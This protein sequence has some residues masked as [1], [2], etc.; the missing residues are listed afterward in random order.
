MRSKT[1]FISGLLIYCALSSVVKAAP[2]C[3]DTVGQIENAKLTD[4]ANQIFIELYAELG[5][6]TSFV[7]LPGKRLL[8]SFNKGKVKGEALRFPIIEQHYTRDFVRSQTPLI[9]STNAIWQHPKQTIAKVKP[10]G[11]VLGIVWQ[12]KH[13]EKVK[14]AEQEVI[15]FHSYKQV[16][17]AY[18]RG[19]IG[20][21]LI[22]SSSL[23]LE[24]N[25][26]HFIP[27]PVM[28]DIINTA[29]LYHYLAVEY[30]DFMNDFSVL[31]QES[32]AFSKL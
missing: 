21:F 3:P 19:T 31:V 14:E 4:A 7:S 2:Y 15:Q 23:N 12:E 11:T 24:K 26:T 22:E 29:Q 27:M 10:L 6:S 30:S 17:D 16:F 13:L 20:S 25:N 5:C 28:G 1:T 8:H 18:N 32:K 9:T